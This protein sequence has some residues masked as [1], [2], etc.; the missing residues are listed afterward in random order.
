MRLSWLEP[1]EGG[2]CTLSDLLAAGVLYQHLPMDPAVWEPALQ[3]LCEQRGYVARDE[4]ALSPDTPQLEALL[5]RFCVEH[6]HTEDEVRFVLAGSGIFDIR[7]VDDRWMRV[8]VEAGDL[9]VVPARRYHRFFLTPERT[10]RCVRLFQDPGGWTP[11][12][13]EPT[14]L[15]P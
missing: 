14:E 6:L 5:G 8:E 4:V 13:R 9:L 7:S 15:P 10:I 2:P 12:Y 1:A 3:T 11:V